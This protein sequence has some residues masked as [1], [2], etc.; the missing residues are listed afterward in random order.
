M[1]LNKD[2][3]LLISKISH[4]LR[5][6]LTIIYSTLQLIESRH[7][8]TRTFEHWHELMKD[9]EFMSVLLD[10]L[11]RFNHA[12]TLN[13]STFSFRPFWEYIS[14]S[15]AASI[16]DTKLEYFSKIDPSINQITGDKTKLQEVFLNLLRNATEAALP[17]GSIS[18]TAEQT[19]DS[20]LIQ[21]QDNGCGISKE[22]I[23]SIFEPFTTYKKNGTG[24]GLSISQNIIHAHHGTIE[25][26]STPQKG[27]TFRITPPTKQCCDKTACQQT[28]NMSEVVNTS[29]C[30][31][32]IQTDE[33]HHDHSLFCDISSSSMI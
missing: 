32:R 6:P 10:D 12:N 23:D 19:C 28:T 20:I 15:F 27:S 17:D 13:L 18:M 25:V 14:L 8:E 16:A 31:S 29:T 7:P 22:H 2:N 33:N 11:S 9:V 24:L 5:N 3:Q 26:D 21:I 4:E 30:E 1:Q